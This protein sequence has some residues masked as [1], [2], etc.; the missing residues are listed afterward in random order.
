MPT[1]CFRIFS[2]FGVL[3]FNASGY[4]ATPHEREQLRL[5]QQQ[6]DTIEHLAARAEAVEAARFDVRYRFDYPQLTED[7]HR[8][9]QGVQHYLSPSRAQPQDPG[10]LVGD[11]RLDTEAAERSP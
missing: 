10:E 1:T 8:I 4:A 9:G 3:T 11:Y 2:L 7:I 5:I 6:L